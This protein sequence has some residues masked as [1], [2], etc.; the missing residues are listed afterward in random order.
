M[1]TLLSILLLVLCAAGAVRAADTLAVPYGASVTL[2]MFVYKNNVKQ[3]STDFWIF[4]GNGLKVTDPGNG[5]AVIPVETKLTTSSDPLKP[6]RLVTL[7]ATKP[8]QDQQ[9]GMYLSEMDVQTGEPEIHN[10]V[11]FFAPRVVFLHGS[12]TL[13]SASQLTGLV[14][15]NIPVK[16]VLLVPQ[17]EAAHVPT[18][19]G[20]VNGNLVLLQWFLELDGVDGL[21]FLKANPTSN[22]DT[23]KNNILIFQN[24]VAEFQIR[25]TKTVQTAAGAA[26]SY[27]GY[28]YSSQNTAYKTY[29]YRLTGSLPASISLTNPA[30]PVLD[31]A[32]VYDTDG[33]GVGDKIVGFY[34]TGLEK[35]TEALTL[36]SN[37]PNNGDSTKLSGSLAIDTASDKVTI[38]GLHLSNQ[39]LFPADGRLRVD[40]ISATNGTKGTTTS[41]VIDSIGPV[42]QQVTL[43]P[44]LNGAP[45]TLIAVFNKE[46]DTTTVKPGELLMLNGLELSVDSVGPAGER[47]WLFVVENGKVA[48]GDKLSLNT[49]AGILSDDQIPVGI[50]KEA[51]VTE[52]GRIPA[53]SEDGNGFYDSDADG[54]MDSVVVTF[55]EPITEGTL[56]AIDFRFVWK[57]TTGTPFEIKPDPKLLVLSADGK[58]VSWA[59]DA[60]SLGIMEFLTSIAGREYGYAA[61]ISTYTINGQELGDTLVVKMADRMAPVLVSAFLSPESSDKN[62]PDQLSLVFSEAVS[63]DALTSRD[64]YLE[65][66]VDGVTTTFELDNK[67][68]SGD[69]RTL[70]VDLAEG[71]ALAE[72]PNPADSL[73]IDVTVGGI[74][75]ASGNAVQANA[76]NVL[77]EGDP[78]VL[79]ETAD[80]IAVDRDYIGVGQDG[81]PLSPVTEKF[82]EDG[83]DLSEVEGASLG[84]MLDVG[85]TTLA[86]DSTGELDLAK[87][88]M[89]WELFVY[90][91]AGAFVAKAGSK[92][93]CSDEAFDGNCFENRKNIY[94]RWNL[95]SEDGR[96]AGVGVY[97][98]KVRIQVVG[99]KNSST[100]EKI[101]TWGVGAGSAGRSIR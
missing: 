85:Q 72:R 94:L 10:Y 56:G 5:S 92:I 15:E 60:D 58:S 36:Y 42:I 6:Y 21:S 68:W 16:A 11:D 95:L 18:S 64:G 77:L 70:T 47:T 34:E 89:D 101:F 53:V 57:D 76:R 22:T 100:V 81:K 48:G 82:Y 43:L 96:K 67:V 23:L 27:S 41:D 97:L 51:T 44:G 14:G 30:F 28:P 78:R 19:M 32:A 69:G 80:F 93:R 8:V 33:D 20:W 45:D 31:R 55:V 38:T 63:D 39:T 65:F 99:Q 26:I 90:T 40:M 74:Q 79:I 84:V 52:A 50:N 66:A 87:I 2:Q 83:T 3:V 12:D 91:A 13:T 29:A 88:G 61:L 59:L 1:K 25:A 35:V 73:K 7:D 17:E 62:A 9:L 24:G 46:L 71:V 86:D 49:L 54:R 37:W 75:D 98:A 4:Y